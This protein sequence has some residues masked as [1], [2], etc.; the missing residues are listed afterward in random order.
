MWTGPTSVRCCNPFFFRHMQE[1]IFARPRL[2][3]AAPAL[4]HQEGKSEKYIKD[5]KEF[6][7][8]HASRHREPQVGG[9]VNGG[10]RS[11]PSKGAAS[12]GH[13]MSLDEYEQIFHK[14]EQEAARSSCSGGDLESGFASR[15]KVGF[16]RQG[17]PAATPRRFGRGGGRPELK[18]DE[19]HSA[20]MVTFQDATNAERRINIELAAQPDY[21]SCD[22][23]RN[24]QLASTSP[25]SLS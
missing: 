9:G 25:H 7:R 18:A 17:Q 21:R 2:H 12:C 11:T 6:A 3:R 19:E 4:S 20:W 13:S 22:R 15:H 10:G 23:W 14:V 5:E 1:L 24:G 16:L 8:D